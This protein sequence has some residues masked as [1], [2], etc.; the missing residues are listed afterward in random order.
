MILKSVLLFI[1]NFLLSVWCLVIV[2]LMGFLIVMCF[3]VFFFLF[4]R[5]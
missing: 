3:V 5:L 4:V 2:F 1:V